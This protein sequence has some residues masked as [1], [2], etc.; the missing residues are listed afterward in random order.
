MTVTPRS[1]RMTSASGVVG[2]LAPSA[3][4]VALMRS[5]LSPRI[6]EPM[7]AG[8]R[9][10]QGWKRMSVLEIA[11][12]PG[13]PPTPPDSATWA[14][15]WRMSMPLGFQMPPLMSLTPAMTQPSRQSRRAAT[16]PTLPKPCTTAVDSSGRRFSSLSASS[17]Q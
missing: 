3:T 12:V 2:A 4:I 14:S 8:T 9:T 15:S 17:T 13:K 7:A 11:S 1:R 16:E 5:A 6:T 10:S